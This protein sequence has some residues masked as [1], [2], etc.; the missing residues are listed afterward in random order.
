ML[1]CGWA[2]GAF[3]AL[4]LTVLEGYC[5]RCCSDYWGYESQRVYI[6]MEEQENIRE[7]PV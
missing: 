1:V 4:S 5:S 7:F 6:L 2:S 3:K